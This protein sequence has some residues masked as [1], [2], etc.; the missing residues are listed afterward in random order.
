MIKIKNPICNGQD[1]FILAYNGKYYMYSQSA[2]DKGFD[3]FVSDDMQTWSDCGR[4]LSEDDCIGKSDFWAPE[5]VAYKGKFVMVFSADMHLGVAVSDFPVGPFRQTDKGWLFGTEAIDGHIFIDN[6]KLYLFNVLW[7]FTDSGDNREEIWGSELNADFTV[8]EKTLKRLIVPETPWETIEGNVVEGPY[9]LKHSG[10]YYMSYSANNY[11]CKDY[12]VGY[13]VSDSPLGD[14]VKYENN[15]ILKS[16]EKYC[17]PGHNS[18]VTAFDDRLYCVYHIHSDDK[19]ILPRK[20]CISLAE[21]V[22]EENGKEILR[23][24]KPL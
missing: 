1:P 4:C 23:I 7:G 12:S 14:Y 22:T 16:G 8:N 13:A 19:N 18:F 9:I 3:A 6:D 21:F 15:P 20:I 10:R 11:T 17:A 2:D 5:V 24:E